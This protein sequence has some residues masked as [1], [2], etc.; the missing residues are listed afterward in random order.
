MAQATKKDRLGPSGVQWLGTRECPG[1]FSLFVSAGSAH[2]ELAGPGGKGSGPAGRRDRTHTP[3][4]RAET[5]SA[6]GAKHK[7]V[8]E[9]LCS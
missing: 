8:L 3:A 4:R 5:G 1:C 9:V 7:R 2:T 6:A